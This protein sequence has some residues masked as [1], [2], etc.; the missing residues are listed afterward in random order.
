MHTKRQK[1]NLLLV[2]DELELLATL[3]RALE[4]RNVHVLCATSG[5]DAL[6]L[7]NLHDFEV[8]VIDV[9]M[10]SMD[11][12]EL[13]HKLRETIPG[14][15]VIILTGHGRIPQAF[16]TAR[17]GVFDYLSK[18]CDVSSL[19][20]KIQTAASARRAKT[21]PSPLESDYPSAVRVLLVDDEIEL[22]ESLA[23]VLSRRGLTVHTVSSGEEALGFLENQI[24]D[25]VVLDIKMPGMGGIQTLRRIKAEIQDTEVILL[26]GHPDAENAFEGMRLGAADY[27]VKPPDVGE[28]VEKIRAAF[29]TRQQR[30]EQKTKALLR[31]ILEKY[32]D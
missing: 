31:Q 15:P 1:V 9:K 23:T 27:I 12:I 21:G 11:G 22:L 20:T 14:L 8:A 4:R 32:P 5:V 28:L 17:E 18:P 19:V 3:A 7:A 16:Q 30:L 13:F 10:P 26:T 24:V 2:D 6:R 29:E 25:V